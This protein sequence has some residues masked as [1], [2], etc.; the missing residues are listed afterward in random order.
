[1]IATTS[2]WPAPRLY[3]ILRGSVSALPSAVQSSKFCWASSG[4]YAQSSHRSAFQPGMPSGVT[5]LETVRLS[6]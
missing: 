1:M 5:P 2:S 4:S 6:S 3:W